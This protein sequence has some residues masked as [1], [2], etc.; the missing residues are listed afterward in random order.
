MRDDIVLF[1]S[2]LDIVLPKN[3]GDVI[4]SFRYRIS[5]PSSILAEAPEGETWIIRPAGQSK[6]R[7]VLVTDLPLL[8]NPNLA[9]TKVPDATPGI[10]AKYAF[11]DEQA[12]LARI[13]YNRLIDIFLGITS[14]SLQNHLRT[15]VTGL[16]QVETDEVYVGVDKRGVHYVVPVQAKGGSDRLSRVQI[17][18][19]F[20]LCADKLP[21]LICRPVGAQIARD[22]LIV[23]FEFVQQ[24]DEI[25]VATEKHYKLVSPE[26]VTEEDLVRYQ[27]RE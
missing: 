26:E 1:A 11:N 15:S 21:T 9:L 13:R 25:R 10:I 2:K 7:F 3:L 20:A 6:Y 4:Y 18:Q 23:L 16:G 19:D 8:P 17:E 27:S 24:G 5:L 22:D 12:V 14:Y